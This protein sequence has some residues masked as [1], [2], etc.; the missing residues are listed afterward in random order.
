KTIAIE[1]YQEIEIMY[2]KLILEQHALV[3]RHGPILFHDN[4]QLHV[5]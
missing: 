5:S 2:Q 3:N 1:C 4:T